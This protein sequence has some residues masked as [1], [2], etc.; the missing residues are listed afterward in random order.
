MDGAGVVGYFPELKPGDT[1]TYTSYCPINTEWGTMEGY[2]EFI[3]EGD[4]TFRAK[5][6]R[7][8]LVCPKLTK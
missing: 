4:E 3:R 6:E 1:F 2:F 7:F 8:Y 5:I